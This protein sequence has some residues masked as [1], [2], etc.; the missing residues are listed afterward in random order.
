[1]VDMNALASFAGPSPMPKT[2]ISAVERA[3]TTKDHHKANFG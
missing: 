3:V 1:M 2:A